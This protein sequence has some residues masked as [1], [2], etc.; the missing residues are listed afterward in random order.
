MLIK[1]L[2][3]I[4]RL[5][6]NIKLFLA[7]Y[8]SL[9]ASI[10]GV[11]EAY[12]Y[13]TDDALRIVLG[14]YWWTILY[15]LPLIIALLISISNPSP[16]A[17]SPSRVLADQKTDKAREKVRKWGERI[18][19]KQQWDWHLLGQAL[20]YAHEAIESDASYQRPWTLLADIYCLLGEKQ[21][22]VE[23]LRK[24]YGLAT[25]GPHHP[26]QFYRKVEERIRQ[27]CSQTA[28][29]EFREKYRRYWK[30]P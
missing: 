14:S 4:K 18:A 26:G 6:F 22:A 17:L 23:C 13:F 21:L 15:G 30:L 9:V 1:A 29:H 2:T 11:A 27:G 12:T 20:Q 7:V 25:P 3:R 19:R 8:F 5:G 10:W 28:P 16:F 24:S